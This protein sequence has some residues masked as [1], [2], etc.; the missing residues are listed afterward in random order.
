MDGRM[1][2]TLHCEQDCET[3][4]RDLS[5]YTSKCVQAFRRARRLSLIGHCTNLKR[6]GDI[7]SMKP[8]VS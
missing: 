5:I 4:Y 8:L 1:C 7:T 2:K 6:Q 3:F